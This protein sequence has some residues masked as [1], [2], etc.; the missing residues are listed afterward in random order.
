MCVVCKK[1]YYM[2]DGACTYNSSASSVIYVYN[3]CSE[4][5][6][7]SCDVDVNNMPYC[8]Q[9]MPNYYLDANDDCQECSGLVSN[10]AMCTSSSCD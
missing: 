7:L 8:T 2:D 4:P 9:C 3:F 5:F 10:C 6:C 1:N